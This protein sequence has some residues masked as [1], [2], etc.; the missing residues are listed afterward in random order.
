MNR[1]LFIVFILF[2]SHASSA[3]VKFY[4]K[5]DARK[6]VQG[7]YVELSFVLENADARKFIPPKFKGLEK[8]SGPSTSSSTQVYNGKVSKTKT[9]IYTLT[10]DKIGTYEIGRASVMANGKTMSSQPVIVE[11]I[12]GSNKNVERD[13]QAFV[14]IELSDSVSYVGAQVHVDYRLFTTLDVRT[15]NID[16]EP[17]FDGFYAQQI[18]RPN[19][20]TERVVIDG[21]EYF[22]KVLRRFALFPQQTGSYTFGPSRI[23]LGVVTDKNQNSNR[24]FFYNSRTQQFKTTTNAVTV[25]VDDLPRN[26]PEDFSGAVGNYQMPAQINKRRLT[27]DDPII[28]NMDIQGNGDAKFVSAPNWEISEGLEFYDPNIISENSFEKTGTILH[29]KKFEYL[30]V[31][32]KPGRYQIRPSITYFNPDSNKYI[33][34]Q[35][36]NFQVIVTQGSAKNEFAIEKDTSDAIFNM[37]EMQ[38]NLHQEKGSIYGSI[39]HKALLG[40]IFLGF[41]GVFGYKKKLDANGALDPKILIRENAATN[42]HEKLD[43]IKQHIYDKEHKAYFEHATIALKKYIEDRFEIPAVHLKK[44]ALI[45]ALKDV[46]TPSDC[47]EQIKQIMAKS[48]QALYAPITVTDMESTHQQISSVINTLNDLDIS[49]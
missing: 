26:G 5:T 4:A 8:V 1:L 43:A 12:K 29:K 3:Q 25:V 48:E 36:G 10:S 23:S 42:A 31:A 49:K 9:W 28:V 46:Q 24:G 6:I 19:S 22:T 13:K 14:Q 47:L 30:L 44:D 16:N 2:L 15:F 17:S 45:D 37:V 33:T 40:L 11:V 18:M 21:V 39:P 27:T 7:S 34:L 35:K 20:Q 38:T 32:E 41:I